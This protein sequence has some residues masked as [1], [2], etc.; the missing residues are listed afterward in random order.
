MVSP[1][2]FPALLALLV[3]TALGAVEGGAWVPDPAAARA[4]AA[5]SGRDV[6][7]L[8]TN[9]DTC[10]QCRLLEGEVLATPAFAAYAAET[11]VPVAIEFPTRREQPKELR[12]RNLALARDYGV[13]AY[14]DLWLTDALGRP[15]ARTGYLGIPAADYVRHLRSLR[16]RRE[17]RDGAF[18]QAERSTGVERARAL[19]RGLR[20]LGDDLPLAPYRAEIDAIIAGDP[21][22]SA[23]IAGRYLA[24]RRA[25]ALSSLVVAGRI[26]EAREGIRALAADPAAPARIRQ[27]MGLLDGAI[28]HQEGDRAGALA[29]YRAALA[30]DPT[31][32]EA[33]VLRQTIADLEA[34]R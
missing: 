10:P 28:R 25:D 24:R 5:A 8:F 4:A 12:E 13:Q 26:A 21:D 2:R 3:A 1:R 19:D 34:G 32:D 6:L 18:A 27:D 11:V 14:P 33:P 30:A 31:S 23:G 16:A 22:G 20:L 29:A 7:L 9:P 15:Y 17:A